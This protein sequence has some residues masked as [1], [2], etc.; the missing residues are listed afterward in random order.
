M[1]ITSRDTQRLTGVHS[2]LI[3]VVKRAAETPAL[4][5]MVLEGVRTLAKQR[6]YFAAGKS[7]TMNSRHL[8]KSA[9]GQAGLVSHAV[10]LAPLV[11]LDGD[12]DI[13]L[14]W[15]AKH[16]K[17]IAAA[18]KTAALELRVPI[19]WGGDWISFRD[20]PHFELDRKVYP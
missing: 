8:P 1:T 4:N 11:D 5:F 13:E 3:R 14:S 19:I 7:K 20:S 15:D 6:E 16:F 2:D 17:P 12:G 9:A 10:D 18:M